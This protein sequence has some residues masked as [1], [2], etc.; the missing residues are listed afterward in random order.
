MPERE[1]K[2]RIKINKLLEEACLTDLDNYISSLKDYEIMQRCE[3]ELEKVGVIQY[4]I[5]PYNFQVIYDSLASIRDIYLHNGLIIDAIRIDLN[6]ADECFS[7]ENYDGLNFKN[8]QC[9]EKMKVHV[10]L[11]DD[12]ISN[13]K[14]N[15]SLHEFYLRLGRYNLVLHDETKSKFY[16][17]EFQNCKISENHY[18]NWLQRYYRVLRDHF[19]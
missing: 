11:A 13:I 17:N 10:K 4:F 18:A 1:A 7:L 8:Q 14:F 15:P 5:N 3:M 12:R 6:I 9:I 2:A 19:A 16:F